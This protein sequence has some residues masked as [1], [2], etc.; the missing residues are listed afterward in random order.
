[1]GIC[2]GKFFSAEPR[3]FKDRTSGL[4]VL[5]KELRSGELRGS[6]SEGEWRIPEFTEEL[7]GKCRNDVLLSVLIKEE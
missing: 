3:I 2:S 5:Q 6:G 4:Q 1:M 7:D